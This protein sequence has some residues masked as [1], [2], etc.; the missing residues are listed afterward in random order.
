LTRGFCVVHI[1]CL[2]E[3]TDG[4]RTT[5]VDEA[6]EDE[7]A[8]QTAERNTLSQLFPERTQ[9]LLSVEDL[10]APFMHLFLANRRE[11]E[12]EDRAQIEDDN[13]VHVESALTASPEYTDEVRDDSEHLKTRLA[14]F[15]QARFR[16]RKIDVVSG[17]GKR[18]KV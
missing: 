8:V 18:R 15:F 4:G 2:H 10:Y 5:G 9:A 6:F 17:N 7:L 13:R 3:S 12:P 16:E 1:Q 14:A 11:D